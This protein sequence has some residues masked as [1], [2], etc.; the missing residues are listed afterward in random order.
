MAARRRAEGKSAYHERGLARLDDRWAGSGVSGVRFL[1][2]E[3]PYAGDLDLFGEG[4]LFERLCTARTSSGEA[5]LASWLL[6]PAPVTEIL[7]RHAAVKELRPRLDLREDLALLGDDVRS[8][9]APESLA[10]WGRNSRKSAPLVMRWL[11]GLVAGATLISA[12]GW[13]SGAWSY[14]L[15]LGLLA[16]EGVIAAV[17]RQASESGTGR[18]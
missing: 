12:I 18:R 7:A 6:Q 15:F 13:L 16:V 4:S 3:H 2:E 11:I 9:V 8:G 17:V 14:L 10:E 1:D 5:C